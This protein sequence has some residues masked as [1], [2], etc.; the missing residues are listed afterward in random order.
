MSVEVL[1]TLLNFTV[2]VA[3]LVHFGRKPIVGFFQ[4]RSQTIGASV[5]EAKT[6][7]VE[8]QQ[9]LEQWESRSRLAEAEIA[10]QSED[11]RAAIVKFRESALSRANAESKRISEEA[12]QV[13]AAEFQRAKRVLRRQIALESLENAK[14][15]LSHHVEKKDARRLVTDYLERVA[16]GHSG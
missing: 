9:E 14:Q 15:Y 7:F 3:I 8:A 12:D 2:V 13:N 1:S 16:N 4:T 5:N 10:R 6:L 11:A